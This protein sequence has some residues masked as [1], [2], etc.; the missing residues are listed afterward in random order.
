MNNT[1]LPDFTTKRLIMRHKLI[2]NGKALSK[3]DTIIHFDYS[4]DLVSLTNALKY[5]F[6][7]VR[8]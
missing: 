6:Y 2:P 4:V 5:Q 7:P 3:Y 8:H 1:R